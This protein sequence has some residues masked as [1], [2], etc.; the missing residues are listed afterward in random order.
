MYVATKK[1]KCVDFQAGI[2]RILLYRVKLGIETPRRTTLSNSLFVDKKKQR[3]TLKVSLNMKYCS[4]ISG[5]IVV[6]NRDK[7]IIYVESKSKYM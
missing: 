4:N 7:T 3:P 5:G 6:K 1:D 2:R